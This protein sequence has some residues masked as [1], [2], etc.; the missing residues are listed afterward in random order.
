MA[1]RSRFGF[2]RMNR[3]LAAIVT[4]EGFSSAI[5]L[6]AY[7]D[8]SDPIYGT[9]Y[10]GD[11]TISSN[12][13]LTQDMYYNNLTINANCTLNTAGYRVFVKNLLSMGNESVLGFA[14][15]SSTVGSIGAG[16]AV[17]TA[18]TNSLGGS[19]A[20]QTATAPTAALGGSKYW[21]QP[22]QAVRGWVATASSPTPTFLNGGAGGV[23]QAGG[24]VVIVAARYISSSA[25]TTNAKIAAPA[26][27]PAGGGVVIVISSG[28]ALPS[29]V[30]TDVT[31]Q[32]S[33]TAIYIQ[34]T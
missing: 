34:V 32:N 2:R 8:A 11:V 23:G 25:T 15:G 27:A 13:T 18:V 30:S 6:A 7:T 16:G 10:D 1:N 14:T 22:T 28:T 5:A 9:G 17:S 20:T 31:G 4:E 19:S 3:S 33:G 26:T 12:T 29:N 21:Y 24:G